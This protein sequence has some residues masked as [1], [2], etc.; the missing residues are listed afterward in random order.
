MGTK[1][2]V[3]GVGGTKEEEVT[4]KHTWGAENEKEGTL[5]TRRQFGHSPVKSKHFVC[6]MAAIPGL[7]NT[8]YESHDTLSIADCTKHYSEADDWSFEANREK[9][10]EQSHE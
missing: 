2:V 1:P 6:A 5:S 3:K 9:W 8:L 4:Y 7:Q 10:G